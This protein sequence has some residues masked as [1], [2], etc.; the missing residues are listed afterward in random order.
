MRNWPIK[1]RELR[2][3][4]DGDALTGRLGVGPLPIGM[5][6]GQSLALAASSS[7]PEAATELIRFLASSTSQT[8]LASY[9]LP[10]TRKTAYSDDIRP[11]VPHLDSIRTAVEN[12][13]IRPVNANYQAASQ[14]MFTYFSDFVTNGSSNLDPNF[15]RDLQGALNVRV[16]PDQ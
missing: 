14:V 6:G 10:A 15:S 5:L 2:K 8:I 16:L 11:F 12:A 3:Y 7:Q 4:L 9:S 1:Y 13:R